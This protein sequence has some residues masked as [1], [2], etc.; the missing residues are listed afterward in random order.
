MMNTQEQAHFN[1]IY[2]SYLNELTL[3]GKSVK[4]IDS[5]SRCLRQVATFFDVCPVNLTT[6]QLKSY[7]HYLVLHKSWSMVK[8]SRCAHSV[9][10]SPCVRSALGM[11]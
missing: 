4:T 5:Y 7:F 1:L 11:G 3:Q 9:F 6:D 2:Q 8:I 10:I